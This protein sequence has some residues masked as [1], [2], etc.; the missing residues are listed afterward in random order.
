M[1]VRSPHRARR[2]FTKCSLASSRADGY[3]LGL[4]L[5]CL[6]EV[7]GSEEDVMQSV[8][9]PLAVLDSQRPRTAG[10]S[11]AGEDDDA[12][13]SKMQQTNRMQAINGLGSKK[14]FLRSSGKCYLPVSMSG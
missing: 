10:R 9:T 12:G 13:N 5:E 2:D 8:V 7:E 1:L 3:G 14:R 6:S 4:L 11:T